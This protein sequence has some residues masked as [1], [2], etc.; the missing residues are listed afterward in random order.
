MPNEYIQTH[1]NRTLHMPNFMQLSFITYSFSWIETLILIL[2]SATAWLTWKRIPH[3]RAL[4]VFTYTY[5]ITLTLLF[6]SMP[7]R[8]HYL[9][10]ICPL[11]GLFLAILWTLVLSFNL[12]KIHYGILGLVAGLAILFQTTIVIHSQI[13]EK[14]LTASGWFSTQLQRPQ[15]KY[16]YLDIW[17]DRYYTEHTFRITSY[18]GLIPQLQAYQ[19]ERYNKLFAHTDKENA[20]QKRTLIV[21]DTAMDYA[22]VRWTFL[23]RKLYDL[24]PIML[25]DSFMKTIRDKEALK[26]LE[27][28]DE[29]IIIVALPTTHDQELQRGVD[30]ANFYTTLPKKASATEFVTDAYGKKL[31]AIYTIAR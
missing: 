29:F 8:K 23:R 19:N 1:P 18:G 28:F 4:I 15:R 26:A 3:L 20:D 2:G 6:A 13:I 10:L 25:G 11:V 22:A 12:K 9:V 30:E 16:A 7:L 31:F 21:Y 5:A 24:Q 27:I 17:L 14:K